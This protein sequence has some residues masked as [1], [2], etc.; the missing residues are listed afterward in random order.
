MPARQSVRRIVENVMTRLLHIVFGLSLGLPGAI[1]AFAMDPQED[2]RAALS[3]GWRFHTDGSVPPAC[4]QGPAE[5][6]ENVMFEF[7]VTGG[8]LR[9]TQDDD[10][11]A[12][13]GVMLGESDVKTHISMNTQ[14]GTAIN[15]TVQAPD[16]MK[17][18][19]VTGG[20]A[21][22]LSGKTLRKCFDPVDRSAIKVEHETPIGQPDDMSYLSQNGLGEQPRFV[23]TRFNADPKQLCHEMMAQYVFFDLIGPLELTMGRYNTGAM[24]ETLAEEKTPKI[25]PDDV[26]NWIVQAVEPIEGG[27]K[28]T[29]LELIPPNGSRGDT[30]T[31]SV[32]A[33][34]DTITIPE[35]KRTFQRCTDGEET[36]VVE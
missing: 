25:V 16:L 1:P 34:G 36:T 7:A 32:L 27:W 21:A 28:V 33:K 5:G 23:D 18:D 6:S 2:V 15:F 17:A 35:W 11:D 24:A 13:M 9:F 14:D 30:T 31:I 4:D 8:M 19:T 22:A 26:G 29:V 20:D 3:G 12:L 10:A